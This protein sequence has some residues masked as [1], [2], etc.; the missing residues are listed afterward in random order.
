[1]IWD[2]FRTGLHD[3]D[4]EAAISRRLKSLSDRKASLETNR[5]AF[6][7]K[8]EAA[9]GL[10]RAYGVCFRVT[11][12]HT[13]NLEQLERLG[14]RIFQEKVRRFACRVIQRHWKRHQIR[15][16]KRQLVERDYRAACGIQKQWRL[17]KVSPIVRPT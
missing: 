15:A 7:A 5:L 17:Y 9:E 4:K 3:T 14:K 8:E 13:L 12:L 10:T 16:K 1:V 2:Y 11:E 6:K